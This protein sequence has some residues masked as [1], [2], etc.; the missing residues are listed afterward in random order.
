VTAL[1]V[2]EAFCRGHDLSFDSSENACVIT[3]AG[4]KRQRIAIAVVE[5][6]HTLRFECFV[7]R[8][9]DENHES[10]FKWLLEQNVRLMSVAFGLDRFGDIYLSGAV[11]VGAVTTDVID[12]TLGIITSTA[13]NA[14]NTLIELGFRSAVE[15]EWA[16]RNSRGL[17]VDNLAAFAH[18][19][20][21][22]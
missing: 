5:G 16:W 12:Q 22:D 6:R 17:S 15:R 1:A 21:N 18:L 19:F 4:E 14:F 13:D 20:E 7:A 11:P 8:N 10:V 2:V 3:I 9:P